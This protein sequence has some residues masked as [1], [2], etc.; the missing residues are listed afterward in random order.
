MP[1]AVPTSSPEQIKS[2][3]DC[4]LAITDSREMRDPSE[5]L[6]EALY[7]LELLTAAKST[8]LQTH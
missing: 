2:R 7:I 1:V 4:S 3:F 6:E 8:P 5:I